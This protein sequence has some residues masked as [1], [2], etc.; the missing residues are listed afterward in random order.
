M[1][2]SFKCT[3]CGYKYDI[4]IPMSEYTEKKDKQKCIKCNSKLERVIEWEG[5][6]D[7]NG[8]Y[9]AVAGRASWQ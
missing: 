7:I 3:K 1:F 5:P 2:Y 4:D 9:E 6:A 8:G